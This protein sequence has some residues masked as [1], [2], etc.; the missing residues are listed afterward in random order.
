MKPATPSPRAVVVAGLLVLVCVMGIGRF[1]YT[2]LLPQMQQALGWEVAQA[3]DVASANFLGYLLGALASSNLARR[4][5]RAY[6]LVAALLGSAST[7]LAGALDWGFEGWLLLRASAGAASAIGMVLGMALVID[8]VGRVGRPELSTAAFPGVGIGIVLSVL[9]I[10]GARFAGWPLGA[11]WAALGVCGGLCVALAL[12]VLWRLPNL[13]PPPGVPGVA[14]NRAEDG[15]TLHRLIAAYGLLGFGYVVTATFIVLMA[16]ERG[17]ATLLEPLCWLVVGATAAPSVPI[18]RALATRFG[19][20]A[21]MRWAFGL[22]ALG[23]L[24]AG[25]GRDPVSLVLGGACLGATF[26]SITAL[27]LNAARR[28]A[29]AGADAALGWMTA[30]FGSGQ[31]LGPFCAGRLAQWRGDFALASLLAAS[32]LLLA[33][34]LLPRTSPH[35][36][37]AAPR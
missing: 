16:R 5:S 12:P 17:S 34:A 10:E 7:T 30:A 35:T 6:W 19:E 14:T 36:L 15:P 32:L 25:M 20:L 26:L 3:G 37:N 8:Y 29:G 33:A 28:A 22:Q 13:I 21:V 11:Q 27:I 2:P 24:L 23:V 9:V 4:P 1:A 31:W 18:G